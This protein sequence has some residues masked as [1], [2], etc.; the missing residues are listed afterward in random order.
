MKIDELLEKIK[1]I[2]IEKFMKWD[3]ETNNISEDYNVFFINLLIAYIS[4]I[5]QDN[6]EK[7]LL[8]NFLIMLWLIEDIGIIEFKEDIYIK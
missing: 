4:K 1:N 2:P 7:S 8:K 6:N 5:Q 3:S